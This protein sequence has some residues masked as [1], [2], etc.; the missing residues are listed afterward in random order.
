MGGKAQALFLWVLV[1][2]VGTR[3]SASVFVVSTIGRN[4]M[5]VSLFILHEPCGELFKWRVLRFLS[6]RGGDSGPDNLGSREV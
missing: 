5:R 2:S 4:G 1:V 6:W 3:T